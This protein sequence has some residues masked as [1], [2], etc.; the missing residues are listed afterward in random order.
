MM[1]RLLLVLVGALLL[2]GCVTTQNIDVCKYAS[3]RRTV[4]QTTI[5]AADLYALSGRNVPYEVQ[6]GR[7][8]AATA[9][10]V[11]NLNCPQR[12]ASS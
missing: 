5:R 10:Q 1:S 11:L 4:Y 2:S 7:Q 12:L 8:A 6:L 9:L 3:A